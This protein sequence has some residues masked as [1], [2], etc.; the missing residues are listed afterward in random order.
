MIQI[1]KITSKRNY[2]LTIK[3]IGRNEL[4]ELHER[5]F[6]KTAL[7]WD[8]FIKSASLE[9]QAILNLEDLEKYYIIKGMKM[10]MGMKEKK[11]LQHIFQNIFLARRYKHKKLFAFRDAV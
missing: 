9:K 2:I 5:P 3:S 8:S 11:H 10:K 6:I 1:K 4:N 7:K